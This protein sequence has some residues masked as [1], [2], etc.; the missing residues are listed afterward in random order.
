[1]PKRD[2]DSTVA[3]IA[4]NILSGVWARYG[5]I[6]STDDLQPAIKMAVRQAREIVDEVKRTEPKTEETR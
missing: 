3:R 6:R 2:Y 5:S 1:M 4:G